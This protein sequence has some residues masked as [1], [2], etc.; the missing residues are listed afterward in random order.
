MES[1]PSLLIVA[2]P[3][4]Q[5]LHQ[6]PGSNEAIKAYMLKHGFQGAWPRCMW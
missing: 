1:L 2:A 6:E 4:N 3:C 5:F